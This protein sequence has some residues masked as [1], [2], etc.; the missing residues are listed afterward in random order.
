[1]PQTSR[2]EPDELD[3][4]DARHTIL[5]A[6]RLSLA[7][8]SFARFRYGDGFSSARAMG[9]QFVLSFIPLVI[10]VVGLSGTLH[11]RRE[12]EVLRR[13]LLRLAP[14][15]SGDA[16]QQALERGA[17]S[18]GSGGK[19][20]LTLGLATA[21]VALTT[22]MG[23]IER[24]ANRLYGIQRDR[25]STRKYLRA[26]SLAFGGGIPAM[27]GFLLL[28]A[29]GTVVD[30]LATVYGLPDG[31][32]TALRWVRWPLGAL[33]DLLAITVLFRWAPR[34]RQPG[35]S[36]LAVGAGVSL[37]LWLFFSGALALYVAT[38][39]SF[40]QV[41]GP[42]T[43]IIALLLWS[44]LTSV[45]LLLG[46]AFAAQLEAV[47]AG[48]PAPAV[49]DPESDPD[50]AVGRPSRLAAARDRLA[51]LS[52]DLSPERQQDAAGMS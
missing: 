36:W 6:G 4:D 34:R 51:D 24:A 48:V 44:Q 10:A 35:M 21:V 23:Q 20:A 2:W 14:G 50:V 40:G 5:R 19:L 42:L 45:A 31:V 30:S 49:P 38:S 18:G 26:A 43:G 7:K 32:A 52:P 12:A 25:P 17:Q 29:G 47:R 8:D 33:L 16:V 9:F 15:S 3:A 27:L 22:S 11:A 39:A 1:V 46:L 28:V 13:A 37:L 41:Y